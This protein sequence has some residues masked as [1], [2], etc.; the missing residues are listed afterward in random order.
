MGKIKRTFRRLNA[1]FSEKL[2]EKDSHK[3]KSL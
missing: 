2:Y 1:A 3:K